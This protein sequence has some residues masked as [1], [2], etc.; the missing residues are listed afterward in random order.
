MKGQVGMG[1]SGFIQYVSRIFLLCFKLPE[2]VFILDVTLDAMKGQVGMGP[3]SGFI[4]YMS[5][6]LLLCFKLPEIE[7]ILDV[8]LNERSGWNGSFP[9][10]PFLSGLFSAGLCSIPDLFAT[11]N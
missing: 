9:M 1:P 10:V 7:F 4:Q 6:I 3:S 8:T 2:I 5:R 11:S